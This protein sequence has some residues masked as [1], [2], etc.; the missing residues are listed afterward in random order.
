MN[1]ECVYAD[2]EASCLNFGTIPATHAV[3]Q[4]YTL[5]NHGI[6]PVKFTIKQQDLPLTVS[7]AKGFIASNENVPLEVLFIPRSSPKYFADSLGTKKG[8]ER[9][10]LGKGESFS[11]G[12]FRSRN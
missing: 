12:L 4:Y 6:Y 1:V 11:F 8:V 7:P 3:S 10:S 5:H 2:N 9:S